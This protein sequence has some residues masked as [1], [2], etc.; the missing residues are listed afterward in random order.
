MA[1]LGAKERR[2]LRLFA[3]AVLG[4]WDELAAA[5]R[6]APEG[7]PDRAWREALLMVHVYAGAPRAVECHAVLE[8]EGGL[9]APRP[10]EIEG[11][12][13]PSARG[14]SL[15]DAIYAK[16]APEVR[17]L[18]GRFHP[19][20]ARIVFHDCYARILA[21]PGLEARL[22]ELLAVVAL[23]AT[24][25]PRQLASHVRGAL[26]CGALPGEPEAALEAVA[27][28]LDPDRLAEARAVVARHAR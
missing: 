3:C 11:E 20:F 9:G 17:A 16:Q 14:E 7:E 21:R 1:E 22:R 10:E 19:D 15:F 27:D 8:R 23:A 6:A 24:G 5:R 26:R 2:L 28:L 4:R 18:L 25:Q 12:R 13:V